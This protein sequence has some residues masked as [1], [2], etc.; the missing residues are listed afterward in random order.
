[1]GKHQSRV[2]YAIPR[3]GIHSKWWTSPQL[4]DVPEGPQLELEARAPLE[5]HKWFHFH[6]SENPRIAPLLEV[7]A[8][9]RETKL[10]GA[11][12]ANRQTKTPLPKIGGG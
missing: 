4:N 5:F 10:E 9:Y 1:M 6:C 12:P 11:L 7:V 8:S 3:E 2:F